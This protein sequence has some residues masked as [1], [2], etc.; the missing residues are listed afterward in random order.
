MDK[1]EVGVKVEDDNAASEMVSGVA[2]LVTRKW[3]VERLAAYETEMYRRE[4]CWIWF[5][6]G[7]GEAMEGVTFVWDGERSLLREGRFDLKEWL[8]RRKEGGLCALLFLLEV[9]SS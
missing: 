3:E 6:D 1:D 2:Y 9:Y 7:Y 5:G 8:M 4:G